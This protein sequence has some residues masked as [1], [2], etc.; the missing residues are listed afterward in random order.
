MKHCRNTILITILA[1]LSALPFIVPMS[2]FVGQQITMHTM[3]EKLEVLSLH[4]IR[5]DIDDIKWVSKNRECTIDGRMFD[6][7]TTTVINGQVVL[8]GLFDDEETQIVNLLS[9]S[10]NDN[11][12]NIPIQLI[13]GYTHLL[14][15]E[16]LLNEMNLFAISDDSDRNT[17]HWCCVLSNIN[18]IHT[19]PPDIL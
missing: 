13:Y 8:V 19:P 11:K 5:M 17:D 7:K 10:S 4:T 12:N 2:L 18:V 3:K 1:A 14:A 9:S 6:V 15:I 16:H